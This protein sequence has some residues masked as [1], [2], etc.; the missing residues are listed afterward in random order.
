[1]AVTSATSAELVAVSSI[2]AYDI[3]KKYFRPSASSMELLRVDQ[4]TIVL[5]GIM[6][7]VLGLIWFY[8]RLLYLLPSSDNMTLI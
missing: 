3:Y 2:G 5:Y 8:S 6:M 4:I 7:G 1:V